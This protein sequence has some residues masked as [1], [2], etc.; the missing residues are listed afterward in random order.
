MK[1]SN[2]FILG[3]AV[4]VGAGVGAGA[5]ALLGAAAVNTDGDS[6]LM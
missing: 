1:F 6:L 4:G 3:G 5:G 2:G